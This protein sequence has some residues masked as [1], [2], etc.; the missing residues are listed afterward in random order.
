MQDR[1]RS[2][3]CTNDI[4]K[5]DSECN[6]AKSNICRIDANCIYTQITCK[7]DVQYTFANI[8]LK[9]FKETF[10]FVMI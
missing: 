8:E 4:C 10:F 9:K 6:F 2:H 1:C 3:I 7:I 5:I